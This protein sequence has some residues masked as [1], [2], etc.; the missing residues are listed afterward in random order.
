VVIRIDPRYFRPTEVESL[1][2][3]PTKATREARVVPEIDFQTLMQRNGGRGFGPGA[4]PMRS[5]RAR[6]SRYIRPGMTGPHDSSIFVAGH[7]GLVG[8]ASFAVCVRTARSVCCFVIAPNSTAVGGRGGAVFLATPPRQVYLA[9]AK[10]GG[11]EAIAASRHSSC[12]DICRF[13]PYHRCRPAHG[14][15]KLL[16]LG[17][18]CIYPRQAPQ[19]MVERAC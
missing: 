17:S 13:R 15:G 3:D 2:G 7:R 11:I 1:L 4:A 5:W 18:S 6:D 12:A 19:P 9:A 10:V 8:S 14:V 16:F